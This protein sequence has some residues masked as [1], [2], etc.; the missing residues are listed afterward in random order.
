MK[1]RSRIS[2]EIEHFSNL[3]EV[4][5]GAKSF[6]GQKR[7]DNKAELFIKL[8]RP[9]KNSK[10]LEIGAGYGEFTRRI[11]PIGAKIVGTDITPKVVKDCNRRYRQRNVSFKVENSDSLSFKKEKFDIVC[12]ISI[13]HHVEYEKTLK[14]VYRVLKKGGK[15]FFTEPNLLNPHILLGLNIPWVR[16]QMEYSPDEIALI[17]WKME[18]LLKKIGFEDVT[19]RNYDFLHPKTPKILIPLI[20]SIGLILEKTPLIKEI[21]GSLIIYAKK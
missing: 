8:C 19:V 3:S 7:Y 6:A 18:K 17:R 16:A 2:N 11:I 20:E 10:I 1:K 14:E 4:W 5:W 21:S 12:G 13:L 15:I 9:N